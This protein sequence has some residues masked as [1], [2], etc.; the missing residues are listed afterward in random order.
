M[1]AAFALTSY[2]QRFRVSAPLARAYE[3][4]YNTLILNGGIGQRV[5]KGAT[6]TA[7][8]KGVKKMPK[9][10]C[11]KLC[12]INAALRQICDTANSEAFTDECHYT[13]F[14]NGIA[15]AV[16]ILDGIIFESV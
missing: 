3:I 5:G 13:D 6:A 1:I 11:E 14:R 4:W 8:E 15:S 10:I 16:K 7:R 2:P 12:E 9:N